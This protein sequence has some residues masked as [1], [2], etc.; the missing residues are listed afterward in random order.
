M[1][2]MINNFF[3]EKWLYMSYGL[4]I[5][6]SLYKYNI[7]IELVKR[8]SESFDLVSPIHFHPSH[9]LQS[10][11]NSI[12]HNQFRI[13]YIHTNKMYQSFEHSN[14]HSVQFYSKFP[15]I[16]TQTN[17]EKKTTTTSTL[18]D[19]VYLLL[20]VGFSEFYNIKTRKNVFQ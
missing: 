4:Q 17:I 18:K 2:D 11:F 12:F 10:T 6:Y 20:N 9:S 13:R 7:V 14:P 3:F 8:F 5:Y 1:C 16:A 19:Q 15:S